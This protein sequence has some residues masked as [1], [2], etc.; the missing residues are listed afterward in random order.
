MMRQMH[1]E[2]TGMLEGEN[3]QPL[4]SIEQDSPKKEDEKDEE[5]AQTEE[6][7][8]KLE[9]EYLAALSQKGKTAKGG[10][11]KTNKRKGK[12]YGE[13]RNCGRQGHPS[14][15]CPV[16]GKLHGGVGVQPGI[17]AAFKGKGKNKGKGGKGAWRGKGWKGKGKGNGKQSFNMATDS[18]YNAAWYGGGEE[19]NGEHENYYNYDLAYN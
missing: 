15:E 7:W 19:D 5:Q 14:R 16:P 8:Q 12:G 1:D 3:A 13:C 2:F 11:G 18:E 17:T 10:K 4:Y 9:Q 6:D